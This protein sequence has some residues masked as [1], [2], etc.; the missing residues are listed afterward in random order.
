M[1]RLAIPAMALGSNDATVQDMAAVYATFA[2]D[3]TYVP[4]SYVTKIVG[5]DG[6]VLFQH[7]HAQSQAISPENAHL[8]APALEQ[9]ITSGTGKSAAIGRPAGGKTGSAQNNSDAWFCGFT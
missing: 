5:P 7:A 9:V 4:P 2:N 3:G 6:A 8:I 1:V